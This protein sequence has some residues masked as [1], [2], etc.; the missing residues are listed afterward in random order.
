MM[1][2]CVEVGHVDARLTDGNQQISDHTRTRAD[3]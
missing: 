1:L 3:Y 2:Q